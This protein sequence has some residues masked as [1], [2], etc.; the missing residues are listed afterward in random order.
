MKKKSTCYIV[1]ILVLTLIA[2]LL[3]LESKA[4]DNKVIELKFANLFPPMSRH[5]KICEEFIKDVQDRTNGRIKIRYFTG[6]SLLK[7]PAIFKGVEMGVA[8][9]G[10]A[11]IVYTPGRMPVSEACMLPLGYPSAWVS[12]QVA[13][14]FYYRF[15]PKEWNNVHVLWTH[16][17]NPNVLISTKPIR[18]L[19]DLKGM[20]LR[21]PGRIAD[22]VKALGATPAPTP[23]M[24]VYDAISKNVIHGVN[25]PFE[26]LKTFRFAEVA[27]YVTESWQVGNIYYFFVVMNKA[28]YNRLPS[29]LKLIFDQLCGEYKE[30]IALMWNLIDTEGKEFALKKGVEIV[31]LPPEEMERWKTKAGLVTQNFIKEMKG[32]GYSETEIRNWLAFLKERIQYWTQKQITLRITSAT[33]PAEIKR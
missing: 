20:I 33:G 25:A 9:I 5:S 30:R 1:G 8:D 19:E 23:M 32:K 27:K 22:T 12:C 31:Q 28:S 16:A 11:P 26:T 6:G 2:I 29:D 14:D 3:P 4:A 10:F 13:N 15:R 17:S 7:G 21:A 24:E 18:R